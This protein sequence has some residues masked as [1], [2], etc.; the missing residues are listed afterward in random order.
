MLVKGSASC[1]FFYKAAAQMVNFYKSW[2]FVP[3]SMETGQYISNLT[4][5]FKKFKDG[6]HFRKFI[7]KSVPMRAQKA[8]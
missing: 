1:N 6:L 5:D 7:E 3:V 4:C 2:N 8:F